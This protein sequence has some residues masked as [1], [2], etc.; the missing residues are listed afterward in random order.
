MMSRANVIYDVDEECLCCY[1]AGGALLEVLVLAGQPR[2]AYGDAPHNGGLLNTSGLA[3]PHCILLLPQ[4]LAAV[5]VTGK[6]LEICLLS[7]TSVRHG[8]CQQHMLLH[9]VLLLLVHQ[10]PLHQYLQQLALMVLGYGSCH[11]W[12]S[13]RGATTAAAAAAGT[14]GSG[15]AAGVAGAAGVNS[16]SCALSLGVIKR[17]SSSN[18]LLGLTTSGEFFVNAFMVLLLLHHVYHACVGPREK[19]S[20]SSSSRRSSVRRSRRVSAAGSVGIAG[21]VAG[22]ASVAAANEAQQSSSVTTGAPGGEQAPV[23]ANA[24]QAG[25]TTAVTELQQPLNRCIWRVEETPPLL[26]AAFVSKL[27]VV[28]L[29]NAAFV[30]LYSLQC[31]QH[32]HSEIAVRLG[33]FLFNPCHVGLVSLTLRSPMC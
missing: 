8:S 5:C 10:H 1:Q 33:G 22:G 21:S 20:S 26:N 19:P 7:S 2:F 28:K 9:G 3:A 18:S 29:S 23:P 31:L 32:A 24:Q 11:L 30:A 4:V 25:D 16:R 15:M 14:A 27:A 13:S 17:N 6:L 12:M